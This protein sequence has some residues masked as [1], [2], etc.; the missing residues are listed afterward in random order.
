MFHA[1][2][3]CDTVSCFAGHGKRTAWQVWTAL[4]ELIQALTLLSTAPDR[5]D[6]D[7]MRTIERFIVL[8][9]DRTSTATD[10]DKARRQLFVKKQHPADPTDKDRPGAA[11]P[12]I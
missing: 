11:S 7:A 1:L 10:I 6:E 12:K 4:P 9:Y 5:I 2:T 8:L 3:G